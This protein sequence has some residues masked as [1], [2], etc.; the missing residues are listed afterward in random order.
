[1]SE[2]MYPGR[3]NRNCALK[4]SSEKKF[5]DDSKRNTLH[6]DLTLRPRQNCK[7]NYKSENAPFFEL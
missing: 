4:S 7:V 5:V 1:M 2:K 6:Y 3:R